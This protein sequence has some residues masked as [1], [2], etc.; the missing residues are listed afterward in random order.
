MPIFLKAINNK[1]LL[2]WPG[3]YA[4]IVSN[5][6]S[7]HKIATVKVHTKQERQRLQLK[8]KQPPTQKTK[9]AH[10]EKEFKDRT[11]DYFPPSD[12]PNIKTNEVICS[13][14]ANDKNLLEIW[15]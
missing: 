13:M 11:L 9:T 1:H 8:K 12:T 14:I 2:T 15:I 3:L 10:E 7:T 4:K 5:D 6:L